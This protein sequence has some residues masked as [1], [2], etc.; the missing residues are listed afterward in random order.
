M[1]RLVDRWI[2]SPLGKSRLVA[3]GVTLLCLM[4][5]IAIA[6]SES[7]GALPGIF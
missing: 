4:A 6:Y 7:I 1:T 5:M 3:L 2:A